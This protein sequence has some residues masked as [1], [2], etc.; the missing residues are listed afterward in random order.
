[1]EEADSDDD[2]MITLDENA[3]SYEP[4]ANR[5]QY[6]RNQPD[7]GFTAPQDAVGAAPGQHFDDAGQMSGTVVPGGFGSRTAI[8]GVPRS[9]IPGL[10]PTPALQMGGISGGIPGLSS[11][12]PA[13]QAPA[14][15]N[16]EVAAA[17]AAMASGR[18][19]MLRAEDAVWPSQHRPGLGIKLPGQV[20]TWGGLQ[21]SFAF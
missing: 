11:A 5:Y 19:R 3:T 4:Q 15:P 12:A 17:A 13:P 10:N 9:A 21:G 14:A 7:A 20:R 2:L 1:M 6:T 8:G 16:P 18:T